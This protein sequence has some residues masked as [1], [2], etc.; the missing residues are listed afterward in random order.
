S[1]WSPCIHLWRS[2][3]SELQEF[4]CDEEL[5]GRRPFEPHDYG[6]CLLAVA[7]AA[8]PPIGPARQGFACVVGMTREGGTPASLLRRRVQML[9]QYRSAAPRRTAFGVLAGA[10]LMTI[11]LG[12]AYA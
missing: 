7:Q 4:S 5:I 9:S 8:S 3:L 1:F 10:L 2:S 12:L 11:P 6:R